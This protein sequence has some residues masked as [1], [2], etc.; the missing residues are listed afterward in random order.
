MIW[1]MNP[2]AFSIVNVDVRWYGLVYA[3]GFFF[4]DWAGWKRIQGKISI[5]KKDWDNFILGVF[6]TGVLGGRVGEFLFYQN[7]Q[8]FSNPLEI[9]KVWNGGMSIHGGVIAAVLWILYW[10]Q[11]HK[12]SPLLLTDAL[13]LPLAVVLIFG[14][15]ANWMNGELWGRPTETDWGVIFP[16]VDNVLRHP[17][18][19]YE[20]AK[21]L[22]LVGIL[23][24]VAT[25]EGW[26]KS[27]IQTTLFL[28]GYGILRFVIEF[29]REPSSWVGPLTTGQALCVGMILA[30]LILAWFQNFW[31]K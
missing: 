1:D 24:L 3:L 2:V 18:Q 19:L 13:T 27:G 29:Y 31:R 8:M 23:A 25:K 14:R 10:S 7:D 15:L 5:Q 6:I 4:C 22:V 16:H 21:N 9:L 26:K 12:V 30:A 28:T 17:S 20:S 11:K